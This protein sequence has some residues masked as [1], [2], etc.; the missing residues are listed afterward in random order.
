MAVYDKL[1]PVVL[2]Y[3]VGTSPTWG[4]TS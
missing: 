1:F 3:G 4:V 2:P